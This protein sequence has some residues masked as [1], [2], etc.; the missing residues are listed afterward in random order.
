MRR[1][2][3]ADRAAVPPGR[4]RPG[5]VGAVTTDTEPFAYTNG[6]GVTYYL[7][8][9]E[10]R[11]RGGGVRPA[12]FFAPVPRGGAWVAALPPGYAVAERRHNGVPYLRRQ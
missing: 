11:V 1:R 10:A 6:R 9:T 5:G 2:A 8:V 12:Y 7:H 3:A 4:T